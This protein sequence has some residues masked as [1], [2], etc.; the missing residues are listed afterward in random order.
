MCITQL[1]GNY[2]YRN[3]GIIE[4]FKLI[5][6]SFRECFVASF[7]SF[8]FGYTPYMAIRRCI[9]Y[10]RFMLLR[11]DRL[12]FCLEAER[13]GGRGKTAA[14]LAFS[15]GLLP[16][17]SLVFV[18]VGAILFCNFILASRQVNIDCI[19]RCRTSEKLLRVSPQRIALYRRLP[20][21]CECSISV[22]LLLS[23]CRQDFFFTHG[24]KNP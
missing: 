5:S 21:S 15:L 24:R 1:F 7:R 17:H 12:F 14:R 6:S 10:G 11:I 13:W 23:Q 8:H 22:S 20:S 3:S 18:S 9:L 16:H 19:L 2:L 4:C